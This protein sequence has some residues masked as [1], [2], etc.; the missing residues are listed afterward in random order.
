[1][2]DSKYSLRNKLHLMLTFTTKDQVV[3]ENLRY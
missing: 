2:N 1:M 3:Q